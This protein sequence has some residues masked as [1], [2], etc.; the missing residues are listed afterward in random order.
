MHLTHS[1]TQGVTPEGSRLVVAVIGGE[2]E[3][4]IDGEEMLKKY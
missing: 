4:M 2:E 1:H 3:L